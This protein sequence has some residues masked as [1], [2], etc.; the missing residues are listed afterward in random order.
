LATV[1][2]SVS[3]KRVTSLGAPNGRVVAPTV[4]TC[5]GYT[6]EP[7]NR[8]ALYDQLI[9]QGVSHADASLQARDL[10]DFSMQGMYK[11]GRAAQE[12]PRRLAYVTSAVVLA[13]LTLL[14]AYG[15]DDDWKKREDWDRNTFWWFKFGDTAFRIPKPFEIGAIGT[16]AERSAELLFDTEMTGKRFRAQVLTL[17]GDNLGMNPVPQLV[18]PMLDVYANRDSFSGRPIETLGMERLKSDH[19]FN[20]NTSMTARATSTVLNSIT[21]LVDKES[22]SPVQ[23]DSLIRGYFG[24]LGTFAVGV[25]DIAARD[26]TNQPTRLGVDLWKVA[27]GGMIR[28]LEGSPSRYVSQVYEQAAVIEQAYGTWRALQ[29]EGRLQEAAEFRA[30]NPG[31]IKA[32]RNVEAIK[33]AIAKINQRIR[34]V[35]K[36]SMAAEAKRVELNRLNALKDTFAKRLKA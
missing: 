5:R 19:R 21:G 31:L 1:S 24:W 11:L 36:S 22:L 14:A 17:L 30:D 25:A 9:K 4:V 8:A 2:K 18:K 20:G 23:V 6:P 15:D 35:E 33:G 16:L 3:A 34:V 26:M 7:I 13:S 10:M 29:K 12:D 32:Y 27:T 28:E